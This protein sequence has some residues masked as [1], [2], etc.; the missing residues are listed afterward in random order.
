MLIFFSSCVNKNDIAII[1]IIKDSPVGW[2]IREECEIQ[3]IT[4]EATEVLL[5]EIRCRGGASSKYFKHSYSLKTNNK[6]SLAGLPADDDWIINANYIDKTFMRHK[7]SYDLYREMNENNL[8]P[9]SAYINVSLNNM[10]KG[11][12]VLMER[13]DPSTSKINKKD[14]KAMIFKEPPVFIEQRLEWVK[15]SNNYYQQKFP[16]I[17]KNDNTEYI[18]KFKDFLFNSSNNDFVKEI[19]RWVDI[20]N[21][22]DW[23]LLLLFTNNSDGILKNFYLYKIDSQTP[24]RIAIWDYDHSF[25]RDG[26]N[27]LNMMTNELDCNRSVLFKR[28]MEIKEINYYNAL[29][30]RWAHLRNNNIFSIENIK[31]HIDDNNS[32]IEKHIKDNFDIW[33]YDS[34]WYFD[35]N[36]YYKEIQ[37]ILDFVYLRLEQLDKYFEYKY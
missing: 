14:N 16:K 13:I 26:D 1:N 29:K 35:D 18:E 28:L 10:P 6:I 32:I 2:H 23:H 27:E 4:N 9:K 11:L 17:F 19:E 37:I 24:F 7:I 21:I 25:G 22:I 12:Y 36:D 31:R 5:A 33:P 30:N 34:E 20:D 3:Y 15:D 8:A